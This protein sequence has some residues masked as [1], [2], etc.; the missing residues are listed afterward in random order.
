MFRLETCIR[1]RSK[2]KQRAQEE[3]AKRKGHEEIC[4]KSPE[5]SLEDTD[6][7]SMGQPVQPPHREPFA[8]PPHLLITGVYRA[9][10]GEPNHILLF[11]DYTTAGA[12]S[13][14]DTLNVLR[15]QVH[16]DVCTLFSFEPA[17]INPAEDI[18]ICTRQV[19]TENITRWETN[20]HAV[21]KFPTKEDAIYV[22]RQ[23]QD[24]S[25]NH[26]K[27]PANVPCIVHISGKPS[28]DHGAKAIHPNLASV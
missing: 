10:S 14:L 8:H 17:D 1:R 5:L 27:T 26:L 28:T 4:R 3:K 13:T 21:V 2:T 16:N 15:A 7:D 19:T 22:Y 9:T 11:V 12:A 18:Q 23:Q 20:G 24:P 25:A 6:E